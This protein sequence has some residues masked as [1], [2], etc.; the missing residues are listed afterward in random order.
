MATNYCFVCDGGDPSRFTTPPKHRGCARHPIGMGTVYLG[1][2]MARLRGEV[3]EAFARAPN[4][5]A[6]EL[7]EGLAPQCPP[8]YARKAWETLGDVYLRVGDDH[9][10]VRAFQ[11]VTALAEKTGD[12]A[13]LHA[14]HERALTI[15]QALDDAAIGGVS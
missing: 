3:G 6:V 1:S 11:A 4:E 10:R 15:A 9:L 13:L 7:L 14:H 8:F 2:G 12:P 5:R